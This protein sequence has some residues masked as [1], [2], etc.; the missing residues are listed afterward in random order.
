M[1]M[2]HNDL[3]DNN[4]LVEEVDGVQKVAGILDFNDALY[5]VRVAEPAI[6]GAYAML[7]KDH[8]LNAMG[9]IIAGYHG[10]TPLTDG[11]LA[12]SL[13][14]GGGAAVRAGVDMGRPRTDRSDGIRR[15]ADAPHPARP[16]P[17]PA[18]RPPIGDSAFA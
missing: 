8:P 15:D 10:V 9:L 18:G 6:A 3:N 11:E 4:V 17:R 5:T 12:V 13:S 7:R 2:V 14:A 1:A 16:A